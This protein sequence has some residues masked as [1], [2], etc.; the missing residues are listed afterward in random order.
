MRSFKTQDGLLY[1]STQ[2]AHRTYI[3]TKLLHKVGRKT[4]FT[5]LGRDEVGRVARRHQHAV[6]SFE[7]FGETEI[8][9]A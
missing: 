5:Y 2:R 8:T 1:N 7:L 9:D 3:H 4:V 6:V